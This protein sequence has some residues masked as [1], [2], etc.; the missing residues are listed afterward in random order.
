M[1][2][3]GRFR[4]DGGAATYV[5]TGILAVLIT[6]CTLGICYPFALVLRERWR[7]K[8]SY[9]DGYPLVFT[10]SATGLFGNWLKW[11]FLSIITLGIYLFW[12]GPRIAEWKWEHT[13]FDR[14]RTPLQLTDASRMVAVPGG[15]YLPPAQPVACGF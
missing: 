15:A 9:I 2:K 5:G 13:D 14:S 4:F 3:S 12:V 1:A 7:A 11:L 8:H 6:V 10:G